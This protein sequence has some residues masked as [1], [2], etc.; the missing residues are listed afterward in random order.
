MSRRICQHPQSFLDPDAGLVVSLSGGFNGIKLVVFNLKFECGLAVG[1]SPRDK[2]Q[3][4]NGGA[5]LSK[6][7]R[8]LC[9]ASSCERTDCED[10]LDLRRPLSDVRVISA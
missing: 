3:I 4:S 6:P 1:E 2:I 10:C 5:Q 7:Y 8:A 9:A